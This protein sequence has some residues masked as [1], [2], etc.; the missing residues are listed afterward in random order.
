MAD[1][2]TPLRSAH[3]AAAAPA[4]PLSGYSP[5]PSETSAAPTPEKLQASI[6]VVMEA[7]AALHSLADSLEDDGYRVTR[8]IKGEGASLS[9]AVETA[10]FRLAQEAES[11]IRKL[12]GGPCAVDFAADLRAEAAPRFLRISDKGRG[13]RIDGRGG[14][15]GQRSGHHI[16]I[17][18]MR[19]RMTMIGGRLQWE[20]QEGEGVTVEAILPAEVRG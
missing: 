6:P 14:D 1:V 18:V 13:C 8:A 12:A 15:R 2:S 20:A 5:S 9:A 11:N 7:V 4:T 17:E 16:G 3:G 19:E 10:L